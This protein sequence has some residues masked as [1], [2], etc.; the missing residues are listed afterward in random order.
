MTASACTSE[1]GAPQCGRPSARRSSPI[2]FLS[3]LSG[4]SDRLLVCCVARFDD[5]DVVLTTIRIPPGGRTTCQ[6]GIESLDILPTALCKPTFHGCNPFI[7]VDGDSTLP[8]CP[9]T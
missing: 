7:G 6:H 8:G 4:Y 3:P 5:L 2:Y 1:S 9:T